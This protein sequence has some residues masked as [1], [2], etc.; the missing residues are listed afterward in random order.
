V[1]SDRWWAKSWPLHVG[2]CAFAA[3]IVLVLGNPLETQ[4]LQWF[5]Q[6]LRWRFAAGWAPPVERS[7]VHLNIDQEDLKNLS[8]LDSEYTT[9][10]RIIREASALGAKAIAFDIVFARANPEIARPLLDAI[11]ENKN[12]IFAELLDAR[13]GQLEPSVL[14]RSFPF[15][16]PPPA[17][18][19]LINLEADSDGVIRHYD[20]IHRTISGRY[21]PSLAF[22]TY[23]VSKGLDWKKDITFPNDHTAQWQELSPDYTTTVPRRAPVRPVLLNIRCPWSVESG[24]AAFDF[25]NLREL[26]EL[27]EKAS[28]GETA[29]PLASKIVFV[30]YVATGQGDLGP[31]VFGAHEPRIYLHSTALDDLMQS[32]W[33]ARTNR[34]WDA[35][36]LLSALLMLGGAQLCRSKWMLIV[37]WAIGVASVVVIGGIV[38]LRFNLVPP[39]VATVSVW[40]LATMFEIGRRHTNELIERQRIRSTMGLYFSPRVLKIGR[41]HV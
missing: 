9:A 33:L 23:L 22:A 26:D 38:L 41:A 8:S 4:E 27:F 12:A 24:P 11:A 14:V 32:R 10:A 37:W 15:E 29:K 35:L 17:P 16:D 19:G 6:C 40:T 2:L 30:G 34:G 39:A 3:A 21:E 5:G 7:I 1:I 36:C 28:A 31:T 25:F 18:S 20:L 13:P